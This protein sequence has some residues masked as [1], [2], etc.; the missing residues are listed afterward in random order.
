[1]ATI[2]AVNQVGES[3]VK[4]LNDRRDLLAAVGQLGDLPA[5]VDIA[6]VSMTR[7]AHDPEP[8][9][10]LTFTLYRIEPSEFQWLQRSGREPER[11]SVLGVD[12]LFLLSAWS[13]TPQEE[14]AMMAWAMLELYRYP[15]L[16]R[17]LLTGNG[18][19]ERD[20]TI[21]LVHERI[22]DDTLFRLWDAL[23]RRYRLSTAYRARVVRLTEP[24]DDAGYPRVVS[25]QL[26][27]APADPMTEGVL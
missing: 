25:K 8:T 20:E 16:D 26:G 3:V 7:I 17:S 6:H 12:L 24:A 27:F 13:A 5:A 1:M 11:P 18:V 15:I 4:L 21:Q 19:W 2:A 9:G 14:Q 10:G 22:N 23:Q